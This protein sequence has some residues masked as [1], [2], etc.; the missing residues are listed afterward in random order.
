MTT[1]STDAPDSNPN[2]APPDKRVVKALVKVVGKDFV[3]TGL[4]DRH[5]YG[6]DAS[7]YRGLSVFAVV[8]P[9][10]AE[11]VAKVV[12]IARA[13]GLPVIARGAGTGLNGGALPQKNA[14]VIALA[15]MNR[16][17]SVDPANRMAQVEP[18]V[19]N[20]DLKGHLNALGYGLTYVPDPGSQVV[21]TIGGNVGNNAGGMHCLKY[22]VT[23]NHVLGLQVVLPDGEI[24]ELGGGAVGR[25]GSDLTAFFVGS[26]GTLGIVTSI[27]VR[28][29]PLQEEIVTQ[30]ALFPSIE[31]AA[32]TVSGIM[33]AGILPAALEMLDHKLMKLVDRFHHVGYPDEA[34]AALIIEM[35]GLKDGLDSELRR[36]REVCQ[37][38]DALDIQ[39]AQTEE[40]A[41]TLWLSR[42][43]AYG[44]M[45]RLS[46]T[47]YVMDCA[48]PRNLLAEAIR[49][50][51]AI[52]DEL[53]LE[54]VTVAHAGDGNLHPLIPFNQD[55]PT[56]RENAMEAHHQIM[57]MCVDLGGTITGEHG[58]GVEKQ[59]EM[60]LMYNDTELAVMRAPKLA[61]DPDDLLNPRKI[62]PT[63][64]FEAVVLDG[65]SGGYSGKHPDRAE[66][67]G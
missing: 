21:S 38:N 55:D 23:S 59:E 66:E 1:T 45:A 52:C 34:G 41:S 29:L 31:A 25:P 11:E 53:G 22:G 46:P 18:G 32:N 44:V 17:V 51:I 58:V 27:K 15:R 8:L 30:L 6:Y 43:A 5:V 50:V 10:S 33:A 35:D 28:I 13:E 57:K 26:E 47:V 60:E 67:Q 61:L 40:E 63:R 42:R 39:T 62:F 20:Q 36:V 16:V 19:V 9:Q 7:V 56:S 54:V 64:M 2:A 4:A 49:G 48:V 3:L 65:H 12:R 14:I 37:A 24:V